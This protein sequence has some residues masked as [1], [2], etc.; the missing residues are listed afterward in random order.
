MC[1]CSL[2]K[3]QLCGK[4]V[5]PHCVLLFVCVFKAVLY[6]YAEFVCV[7]CVLYLKT[8]FNVHVNYIYYRVCVCV[9]S[10]PGGT[11]LQETTVISSILSDQPRAQTTTTWDRS[12]RSLGGNIPESSDQK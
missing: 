5:F 1:S 9:F 4:C 3:V 12:F 11:I 8:S 7:V 6:S 2:H 10:V